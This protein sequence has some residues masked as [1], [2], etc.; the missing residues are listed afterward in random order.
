M[1]VAQCCTTSLRLSALV[2][3]WL[4]DKFRFGTPLV[5]IV[6]H[7]ARCLL[8]PPVTGGQQ[9]DRRS[10]PLNMRNCVLF[11]GKA[12]WIHCIFLHQER[13]HVDLLRLLLSAGSFRDSTEPWVLNSPFF[14]SSL[15][16][17]S[18]RFSQQSTITASLLRLSLLG[19]FFVISSM[20]SIP[21]FGLETKLCMHLRG[22]TSVRVS[23]GA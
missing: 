4:G 3:L 17:S 13:A 2:I 1:S 14:P 15:R 16:F 6:F 22:A 18:S 8:L 21:S 7:L 9:S 12:S 10:H 23:F 5:H 19:C 11:P 20:A